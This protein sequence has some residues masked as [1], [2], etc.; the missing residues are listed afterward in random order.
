MEWTLLGNH[1]KRPLDQ[2]GEQKKFDLENEICGCIDPCN[3]KIQVKIQL[4]ICCIFKNA[5]PPQARACLV[6]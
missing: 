5:Y 3:L 4:F 6:K 2:I 1:M